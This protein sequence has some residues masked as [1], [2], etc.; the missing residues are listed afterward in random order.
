MA[1]ITP[2]A[3]D[4]SVD[5]KSRIYLSTF[6]ATSPDGYQYLQLQHAERRL[7]F[8]T[9]IPS[10]PRTVLT[11]F[12]GVIWFDANTSGLNPTRCQT[13]GVPAGSAYTCTGANSAFI[14]AGHNF[15]MTDNSD[16][17]NWLDYQYNNYHVPTDFEYV[18]LRTESG[19]CWWQ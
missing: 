19:H 12:S 13:L 5:R 11:G 14:G 10:S 9:S 2:E 8:C 3:S 17:V 15:M 7:R 1:L 6:T 18:G 4:S 16:P